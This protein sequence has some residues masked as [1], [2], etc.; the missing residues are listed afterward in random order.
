MRNRI[1]NVLLLLASLTPASVYALGL[2]ELNLQSYLSQP[3]TAEIALVGVEPGDAE[4]LEARL[5]SSKSHQKAGLERPF[6]LSALKFV[7]QERAG[8][9]PY[10]RVST[11]T[12]VKEP[13]FDFLLELSAPDGRVFRQYTLLL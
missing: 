4:L 1:F 8:G 10:I 3:L 2:G 7:V 12:P 6:S 11:A 13:F 9:N 5:A